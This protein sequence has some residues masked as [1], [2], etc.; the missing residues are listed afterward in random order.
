MK[1]INFIAGPGAGKS[2]VAA[3]LFHVMKRAGDNVELVSEYAKDM[4]WEERGNILLDQMYIL[5]KQNRRLKRLEGKVAYT[6]TDSPLILGM[7]YAAPSY[8]QNF[9]PLVREVYDSYDNELFMIERTKAYKKVGRNQ[10]KEEAI[11]ID[12]KIALALD[13]MGVKYRKISYDLNP[14]HLRELIVN[15]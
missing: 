9:L 7:I 12:K 10:T 2:T 5:A 11:E 13:R 3:G 6:I 8:Y 4:T 14:L 15:S 1:V